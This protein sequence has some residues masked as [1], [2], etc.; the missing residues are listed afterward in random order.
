MKR[1][2]VFS[3]S[4][5]DSDFETK[6]E[7]IVSKSSS[8]RQ[9]GKEKSDIIVQ[10]STDGRD[11]V[12]L[13][14][15]QSL[16][17]V[18]SKK[19][20]MQKH[21]SGKSTL[22]RYFNP[23]TPGT[24]ITTP[25]RTEISAD[26][27]FCGSKPKNNSLKPKSDQKTPPHTPFSII[28]DTPAISPG[29]LIPD[30]P[31]PLSSRKPTPHHSQKRS[32]KPTHVKTE[33]AGVHSAD[34]IGS[35]ARLHTSKVD[36]EAT[37]HT[38][39]NRKPFWAYQTRDG[40]RA[41]GSKP[42][43]K[44][45]PTCLKGKYFVITGV[46]ESIERD[47]ARDLI[48]RCGGK[49]LKTFGKKTD[50]LVVGREPGESKLAKA[51]AAHTKQLDEDGLFALIRELANEPPPS[52]EDVT[53]SLN[54]E[55][56]PG[57]TKASPTSSPAKPVSPTVGSRGTAVN[58]KS[59]PIK[60]SAQSGTCLTAKPVVV[61]SSALSHH[62]SAT[63]SAPPSTDPTVSDSQFESTSVRSPSNLLWVEKYKPTSRRNLI[64]QT[65]PSSP[66]SRLYEWLSA[67]HGHFSAGAKAHAYSSAPPWASGS[68]G[69]DG[70]WARAALLS[71]PPGIGKTSSTSIVC[72]ELGFATCEL[73]ASDCRS[74]R[75]LQEE[76]SQALAMTNLAQ[77]ACGEASKLSTKQHVL[78]MD[79]VDGM[80]G[81][82]DRG[83]IQELINMIKSTRIPIICMCNDRQ[84]PKVRSL[85]NYCLDLRFHRPRVEQIK[86]AVL[87]VTC[88]ENVTIP[89]TVLADIIQASNQDIRQ[90]F[91]SV[92]M[93]CSSSTAD[94]TL[95]ASNSTGTLKDLRLSAFDVVRKVFTP[96]VSGGMNG[97]V[98]TVNDSLDLFFQ[99]YSLMP[100]FVQENYV[101][102]KPRAAEGN[103]NKILSLLSKASDD[104]SL[105]DLV[106]G[107]IRSVG[108]GAWSLLPVQGIFSVV[109][110]G[111]I[112][113]GPLP[114]GGPG[115]GV[116]FPS[117]FG[118]YSNQG[119]MNRV[120]TE[121]AHHLSLATHASS[122]NPRNLTMDYAAVLAELLTR[123]LKEGDVDTVLNTL[124][125]Y[126]LQRE[127]LD[128]ILELTSWSNR[129]NRML[130]IDS[131][132]K[133]ALTRAFNKSAHL[134]PYATAAITKG[135]SK[136][137]AT[138]LSV[139]GGGEFGDEDIDADGLLESDDGPI[140]KEEGTIDQNEE[141]DIQSDAMI[142]KKKK[143][144][145]SDAVQS[146]AKK[147]KV[148]PDSTVAKPS[149]KSSTS[150]RGRAKA[151]S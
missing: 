48:E 115:G 34:E 131:K 111:R 9:K 41:L 37:P 58:R 94:L 82:E 151:R 23:K 63:P 104:I 108:T 7:G 55:H 79:E 42:I 127:D 12:Q 97:G 72:T 118:K 49:L 85:A 59:T 61:S 11:K 30:T 116:S 135:R 78:I 137:V 40:P 147:A 91:N 102:V 84:S 133:A 50:Y 101:N 88:K 148:K 105:G 33:K 86:A 107:A 142:I 27:F 76:I 113:R 150:G 28:P 31:S 77:M 57:L 73:N 62:S 125:R 8:K 47:D 149:S 75:S 22:E 139:N 16:Q 15:L 106:G 110:P 100:L 60:R 114:G 126:Q 71:G 25:K 44:G 39:I 21:K 52:T 81:N 54:T 5:S 18:A 29:N 134:L 10:G 68:T 53:S 145:K 128:S 80:A 122:T 36:A 136:R 119:R 123:P 87:S 2:V 56:A 65:G 13:S 90:V 26:E 144:M 89:A 43:P 51:E 141:E 120:C 95:L 99:D 66:A 67:W 121:L 140:K 46:L 124:I 20:D 93:W 146:G 32:E 92:Q 64:G 70:K 143:T 3:E 83:G 138:D 74:K 6:K 129:P 109:R 96:D 132:V 117:W 1:K 35:P 130:G 24:D 38:P 4:D 98:A 69:D 19:T 14:I 112:L 45:N 103:M 17:N